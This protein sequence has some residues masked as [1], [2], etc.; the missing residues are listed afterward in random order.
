[1]AAQV[2]QKLKKKKNKKK[3][4]PRMNHKEKGL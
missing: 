4:D 3:N 1:M 2:S